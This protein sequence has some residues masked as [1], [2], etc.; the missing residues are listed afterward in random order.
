MHS[1]GIAAG[2]LPLSISWGD[3]EGGEH[4]LRESALHMSGHCCMHC[5]ELCEGGGCSLLW[6]QRGRVE[7][8]QQLVQLVR[9]QEL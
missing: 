8:G 6:L 9:G 4:V 7:S 2:W 1:G 5:N 3:G